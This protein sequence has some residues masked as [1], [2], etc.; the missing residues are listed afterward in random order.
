MHILN[1]F[2]GSG[3]RPSTSETVV[4]VRAPRTAIVGGAANF[5]GLP[6]PRS[7]QQILK[8]NLAST[9]AFIEDEVVDSIGEGKYL[10][11][12]EMFKE[13]SNNIDAL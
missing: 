12:C 3:G 4:V 8:E 9:F 10:R 2:G 7:T 6:R 1:F 13:M 5:F 11:L